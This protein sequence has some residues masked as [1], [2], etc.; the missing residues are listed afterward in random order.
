MFYKNE[1]N[2]IYQLSLPGCGMDKCT[3]SQLENAVASEII[4]N[5]KMLEQVGLNFV[6]NC[7]VSL[8]SNGT[9]SCREEAGRGS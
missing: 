8:N 3:V 9:L 4:A 2:N 5:T 6:L 7:S 1:T